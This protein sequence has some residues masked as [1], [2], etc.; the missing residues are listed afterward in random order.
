MGRL[1]IDKN[2]SVRVGR[3]HEGHSVQG[4]SVVRTHEGHIVEM[5]D[6]P[7]I[8]KVVVNK[9]Q[10]DKLVYGVAVIPMPIVSDEKDFIIIIKVEAAPINPSDLGSVGMTRQVCCR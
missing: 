8:M 10:G 1:E 5:T 2:S 3:Q 7:V 6:I 9:R 4:K